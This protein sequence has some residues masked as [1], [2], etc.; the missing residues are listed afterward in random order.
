MDGFKGKW[1]KFKRYVTGNP[2]DGEKYD[3]P[4][5]EDLPHMVD[6]DG[7]LVAVSSGKRELSPVMSA[8]YNIQPGKSNASDRAID[9]TIN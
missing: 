3:S 1:E 8:K 9:D 4:K 7:A 6:A 2:V 5:V